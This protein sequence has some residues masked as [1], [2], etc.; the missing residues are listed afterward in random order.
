MHWLWLGRKSYQ[1][2]TDLDGEY[3]I[4]RKQCRQETHTDS[5]LA[6]KRIIIRENPVEW[7]HYL[8]SHEDPYFTRVL[9]GWKLIGLLKD[10]STGANLEARRHTWLYEKYLDAVNLSDKLAGRK[11]HTNRRDLAQLFR[12]LVCWV[13]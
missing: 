13:I 5:Q 11:V 12:K 8:M 10:P 7:L 6:C 1:E 3:Q 9:P 4:A 2:A